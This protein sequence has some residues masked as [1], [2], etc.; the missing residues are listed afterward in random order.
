MNKQFDELT[1][2]MAQSI[3][4]RVALKKLTSVFAGIAISFHPGA[5]HLRNGCAMRLL[6]LLLLLTL[7]VVVQAQFQY[8][9]N[10]NT[11]TITGYTGPRRRGG[12]S[13]HDH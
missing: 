5:G 9:T 8:E 3:T 13:Q 1:R 12:H 10:N 11:I 4:R 6:P 7:P 2:S